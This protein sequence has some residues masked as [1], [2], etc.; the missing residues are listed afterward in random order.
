MSVSLKKAI[1]SYEGSINSIKKGFFIGVGFSFAMIPLLIVALYFIKTDDI[2]PQFI[3][4]RMIGMIITRDEILSD[5]MA[6]NFLKA[7]SPYLNSPYVFPDIDKE[8]TVKTVGEL[9]K[10]IAIANGN[11]G[12]VIV[13]LVSGTYTLKRT[14]DIKADNIIIV[15]ITG[16]PEDVIIQGSGM[17]KNT[18]VKNL[19]RVLGKNFVLS[20]ITLQKSGHH[21][22]QIA[23][24]Y[25]ADNPVIRNCILLDAYQQM[26]KVSYNIDDSPDTSSDFGL[27]ENCTFKYTAGIGPHYYIGGIDAHGANGWMIRGNK[28]KDI[29]S[30]SKHV[31][32]HAVHFWNNTHNNIVENNLIEDSDRGIGFGLELKHDNLVYSNLGGVIR[33]NTIIHADN[34]DPFAD[35]G[36]VIERSPNTIIAN[37]NIWLGHSY[38]RAIEYRFPLTKNVVIKDNLTNKSI[39]SRNGGEAILEQ[40]ITDANLEDILENY[41]D[42]KSIQR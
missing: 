28:F 7:N 41:I 10:A 15:S 3:L 31:A 16:N 12:N 22:I 42:Q 36:I 40:N 38:K 19:I 24:E 23:G 5:K 13:R 2:S 25:D 4:D 18:K 32:E 39:S 6:P 8:I 33:N 20:G 9:V 14:L 1:N 29:A 35:T 30:P 17:S 21:L 11:K 27:I 34:N 37:N 26:I